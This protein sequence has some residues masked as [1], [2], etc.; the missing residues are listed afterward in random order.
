MMEQDPYVVATDLVHDATHKRMMGD[1][2]TV[3]VATLN[4]GIEP[5]TAEAM[6]TWEL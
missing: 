2:I 6:E 4:R 5:S 1:N 3:I